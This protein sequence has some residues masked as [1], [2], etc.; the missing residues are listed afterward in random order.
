MNERY[1]YS[2]YEK[3]KNP[4]LK[5][6]KT[7]QANAVSRFTLRKRTYLSDRTIRQAISDLRNQGIPVISVSDADSKGYYLAE[8]PAEVKHYISETRSRALKLLNTANKVAIGYFNRNQIE[9]E[10]R[11]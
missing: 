9:M 4:V 7:G 10:D 8:T 3:N 1:G 2:Q 5:H 6:L 11:L